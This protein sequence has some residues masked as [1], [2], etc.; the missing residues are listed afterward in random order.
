L[1]KKTQYPFFEEDCI[2]DFDE[3]PYAIEKAYLEGNASIE[4][5]GQLDQETIKIIYRGILQ[6][7][8]YPRKI[9]LDIHSSL[10]Q[11]GITGLTK[12]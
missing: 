2:L 1:I 5:K 8:Y 6:S 3:E 4:T 10:N 9:I 11:I 7:M 12:P